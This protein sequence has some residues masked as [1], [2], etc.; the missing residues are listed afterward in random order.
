MRNS[1]AE[2]PDIL[3]IPEMGMTM[4]I[5]D[6][7]EANGNLE[8]TRETIWR[9]IRETFSRLNIKVYV[10]NDRVEI[11]GNIPTEIIEHTPGDNPS[12]MGA[13]YLFGKGARGID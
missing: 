2:A 5:V 10:Y 13:D 1:L 12:K 9:N 4:Y 8:I 7:P 6:G 11:R 3:R